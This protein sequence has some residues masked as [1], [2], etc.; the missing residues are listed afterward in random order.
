MSPRPDSSLVARPGW[1]TRRI[2]LPQERLIAAAKV[3][4]RGTGPARPPL[5]SVAA[6]VGLT[7]VVTV[8]SEMS[9]TALGG[10]IK[11]LA[12][13][14]SC[15]ALGL[16]LGWFL[17]LPRRDVAPSRDGGEG[18]LAYAYPDTL[19][20]GREGWLVLTDQR[21]MLGYDAAPVWEIALADFAGVSRDAR[22]T[23]VTPGL[24]LHFAD[25][26]SIRLTGRASS[27]LLA[28]PAHDF[29][30]GRRYLAD[31][32]PRPASR[33]GRNFGY[34]LL[35]LLGLVIQLFVVTSVTLGVIEFQA[36]RAASESCKGKTFRPHRRHDICV[37][38]SNTVTVD[39][40]TVTA[41][42]FVA[43]SGASGERVLC[44]SVTIRNSTAELQYYSDLRFAVQTPSGKVFPQTAES[45]GAGTLEDGDLRPDA[46]V[47]GSVCT[48][49]TGERGQYVLAYQDPFSD[50]R[51]IW[52]FSV[53]AD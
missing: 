23:R 43:R 38:R 15:V 6:T 52:L 5:A 13:L 46:A 2:L 48:A 45:N 25:G 8:L 28:A 39:R 41:A 19:G 30:A 47:T 3:R 36:V 17:F 12:F 18:S 11:L 26:S 37:D 35:T 53:G 50:H 24:R 40:L 21:L 44:T 14:L 27:L 42:P 4:E 9:G 16:L 32:P 10:Q 29:A 7:T 51:A 34:A 22:Y 31:H 49:D 20:P 1:S 33:A